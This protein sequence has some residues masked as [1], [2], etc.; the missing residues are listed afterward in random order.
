L[1]TAIA[2]GQSQ[3]DVT[4]TWRPYLLRPN[5]PKEGV[6][7]EPDTPANP[8]VGQ[9]LKQAG[10]SVGI[11]FTGKTDRSPNTVY[12]HGLLEYALQVGGWQLQN[13]LQEVLFRQYF[14]D[15]LYPDV[16]HL[17]EAGAEVGLAAEDCEAHLTTNEDEITRA[18]L[19]ADK[20]AKNQGVNGVPYFYFNNTDF[21]LS[22]AQ[23]PAVFLQAFAKCNVLEDTRSQQDSQESEQDN[24]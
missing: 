7:K 3:Y 12:A 18:V 10:Q 11:D 15:G 9:R 16:K 6:P 14:T 8:R 24:H 17:R 22:G 5:H 23:D 19:L 2:Q 1:E 21:R 20:R 4:V 13:R